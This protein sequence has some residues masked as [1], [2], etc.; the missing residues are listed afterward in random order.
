MGKK[1]KKPERPVYQPTKRQLSYHHRQQRRQRLIL[2]LGIAVVSIV[3]GLVGGGVFFQWYLPEYKPLH[4]VVL[5]V[6]GAKFNMDYYIKAMKFYSGGNP[7]YIR[8]LVESTAE[9]IQMNE[10]IRQEA[11]LLGYSVTDKEVDRRLEDDNLPLNR[12][13][14]DIVGAQM[15][16]GELRTGYF[17]PQIPLS[18]GQRHVLAVFLEGESQIAEVRERLEAGEDFGLLAA[19]LSL[20]SFS[21]EK[22][23]DLGFRPEGILDGLLD[24]S[25]VDSYVFSSELTVWSQPV[26]DEDKSKGLGYWLVEV[27]EIGEEA[28]GRHVRAMLLSSEE[29]AIRVRARIEAGED[30][31]LLAAEF[32][33]L[34][35]ADE[36]EG[37]LGFITSG[38]RSEAFEAYV[39]DPVLE[40]ETV[41]QPI[42]DEEVATKGGYWLI[43]VLDE[44][45]YKPLSDEDRETLLNDAV[46]EWISSLSDDPGNE[47]TNYLDEEMKSF[48]IVRAMAD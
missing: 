39:F 8:Y 31:G 24:S 23:G 46:G 29:E 33:Q 44:D 5:E 14:R 48:A 47:V 38:T 19:E 1:K 41:S 9:G 11:L 40:L 28:E 37:D 16:L 20:D 30:F 7:Q 17:E 2:G 42:G 6:N 4:Q 34:D 35:G 12:A 36:D 32:S 10:F 22:N 3:L 27:L 13:A 43:N 45:L 25:V 21:R 15:L 18:A 26:Y